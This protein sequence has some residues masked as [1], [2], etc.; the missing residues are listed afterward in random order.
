[1]EPSMA[2][3]Q[4][5]LMTDAEALSAGGWLTTIL[6][7]VAV[8]LLASVTVTLYVPA[9]NPLRLAEVAPSFQR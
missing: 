3:G 8:Q 5:G 9:A 7:A 2:P 4:L 6:D 1:M